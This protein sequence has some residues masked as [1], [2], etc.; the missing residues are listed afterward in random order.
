[1]T[2]QYAHRLIIA[3]LLLSHLPICFSAE[4]SNPSDPNRYL[5]AVRE[6]AD[7]VLKYGRDTYGPKHTPLFVDGLNIYTH[8]PVKWV[9][10]D[11]TKW[12][13]SNFASQQVL[14]RT[15]DG[16]SEITGDLK[17][18]KAA[19]NAIQYTFKNLRT[20]NGLFYWG[21]MIAYDA[22]SDEVYLQ[23]GSLHSFKSIYPHYELMWKVD[24]SITR[25]FIECV[26]AA[27]VKDW[28]NLDVDRGVRLDRLNVAKDWKQKYVGGP[29]YF[30]TNSIPFCSTGMNLCYA[31]VA[32][33]KFGGLSEPIAW[34]K[35]LAHRYVETRD[36]RTGYSDFSYTKDRNSHP[37]AEDFEGHAIRPVSF[38][39]G[40]GNPSR[41]RPFIHIY[42]LSP[43]LIGNYGCITSISELLFSQML[44]DEGKEFQQWA[45]EELTARGKVLYRREDNCW[46]PMLADGTTLEGY[47]CK[48]NMPGFAQKGSTIQAWQADLTDFW[49]Y[50]LA[51]QET[52]D[53]FMWSMARDIALGN[54]LGDIGVDPEARI[55]LNLKTQYPNAHALLAFLC[56]YNKT[57]KQSFLA[58][59]K[60]IGDNIL[61]QRFHRGF[62]VPSDKHTYAKLDAVEALVLLHLYASLKPDC[63]KPPQVWPS[64]ARFMAP[65]RQKGVV[66]DI[67][68]IYTLTESV[69]PPLSINEAAAT[70]D[71]ELVQS[72]LARGSDVDNVEH[73]AFITPLHR[74]AQNGHEE[75]VKLLLAAGADV[76]AK[77][78]WP[79]RTALH[80]AVENGHEGVAEILI[81]EGAEVNA[82]NDI[83]QTPLDIAVRQ[84]NKG[85]VELLKKHGARE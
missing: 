68:V 28:S 46:I 22:Q 56:L 32:F 4:T 21:D 2:Q 7:N 76:N 79:G 14:L 84:K 85:I 38:D 35:R 73:D 48:R 45:L 41:R 26:W 63:P 43:G 62:F 50:A 81:R 25:D 15:L 20:P 60:R 64:N 1:M 52:G 27:H 5:N 23:S 59:A 51:Y 55:S 78:G 65:Y 54:Q 31:A 82:K 39:F 13:I 16:L 80:Y 83:G 18:R 19:E 34:G 3:I 66:F 10:P 49:A 75:I 40:G 6:F 12:I 33:S 74:A 8:E 47:L 67:S 57:Q 53:Q 42:I 70:G 29:I 71:T 77:E 17:Y 36:P 30:E 61:A 44:G 24:P 9:N 11:N 72:L 37:L 69:D 58:M